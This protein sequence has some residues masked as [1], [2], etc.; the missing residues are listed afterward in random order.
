[1]AL[2]RVLHYRVDNL[3]YVY[4]KLA[5]VIVQEFG[6]FLAIVPSDKPEHADV[7][8]VVLRLHTREAK[9]IMLVWLG[10]H[11][12]RIVFEV[13]PPDMKIAI[14]VERHPSRRDGDI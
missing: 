13:L 3:V 1:M 8:L 2:V 6:K 14:R 12:V 10:R 11:A 4:C 9:Q 7:K 5:D